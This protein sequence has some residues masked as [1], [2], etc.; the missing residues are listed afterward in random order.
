VS[1][2][3]VARSVCAPALASALMVGVVLSL[4][5]VLSS[6]GPALRLVVLIVASAA[7]YLTAMALGSR[8]TVERLVNLARG[9][10]T[11]AAPLIAPAGE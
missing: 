11:P 8:S 7:T 6:Y 3:R 9:A 2:A 10:R 4:R 5:A 1:F